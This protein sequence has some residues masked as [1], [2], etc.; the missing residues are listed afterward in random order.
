MILHRAMPKAPAIAP[1]EKYVLQYV[2]S[3]GMIGDL[4]PDKRTQRRVQ[5][6]P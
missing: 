4:P 6:F 5:F 3:N 2:I 1:A